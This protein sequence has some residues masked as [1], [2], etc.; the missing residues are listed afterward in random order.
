M[1]RLGNLR[2]KLSQYQRP[3]IL[4]CDEVGYLPWSR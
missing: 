2:Q 1:I 3:Q 4:I